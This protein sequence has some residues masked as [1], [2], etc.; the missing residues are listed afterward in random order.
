MLSGALATTILSGMIPAAHMSGVRDVR[1]APDGKGAV[2]RGGGTIMQVGDY[3]S[4]KV[5][6]YSQVTLTDFT[7]SSGNDIWG[8]VSPSGREYALVGLNN[9]VAFV[10]VTN[11]ASPVYFASIP[12]TSS[13]WGDIKVYQNVAYAVTEASGTG[14]Q[15]IDLSDIDNHQVT[16]VQTI[17]NPSRTHNIAVDTVSGF[18]YTC[19]SRNSSGGTFTACFDLSTPLNPVRVGLNSMTTSYQHDVCPITFTSGPFAGRQIL[20]GN[21]ES[22]GVAI[23]DV[24]DKDVPFLVRRQNYALSEYNHQ[25]WLTA[26]RK[27]WYTN[28]E[29]DEGEHNIMTR[30]LVWNVEDINNP[31]LVNTFTSGLPAIDHNLYVHGGFVFESNYTSGLRIFDSNAS[32]TNPPQIGWFDTHPEDD[33]TNFNG[34]WSN[35]PFLPSGTL[36]VND[37]NRGLFVLDVSEATVKPVDP[38][39]YQIIRGTLFGGNL[40]SLKAQDGNPLIVK[41]GFTL[42]QN[43]PP[44]QVIVEG[45]ALW[46]HASKLKLD[47]A[48]WSNTPGLG[49]RVQMFD[50]EANAWETVSEMPAG[51][52]L[53][54]MNVQL[55]NPDR[56]IQDGT[57]L[58]RAKVQVYKTGLTL[59]WPYSY[60]LD[61]CSW[62]I[63]P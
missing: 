52:S 37:I 26:D 25:G 39:S 47:V 10:E 17:L 51:T 57:R 16:L 19:G 62:T 53:S 30:T 63:N 6:L 18:L 22:R 11:P 36:I 35:Y 43:E 48:G 44:I 5:S 24:T 41:A 21:D 8:Y 59:L 15:V 3:S 50:W 38:S 60:F 61:R 49:R 20:F 34:T 1:F 32:Q 29:L 58:M 27:Y 7:S 54:T 28:D 14:I 23:W 55:T 12:H 9:K 2:G 31:V 40:N 33:D 42:S 45:T 56:F 13:T 46:E 4:L